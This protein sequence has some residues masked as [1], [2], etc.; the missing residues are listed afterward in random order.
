[1]IV[2]DADLDGPT[3][4]ATVDD[5]LADPARLASMATAARRWARPDAARAIAALAEANARG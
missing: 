4:G 5:L 2:R 1:V 3:L